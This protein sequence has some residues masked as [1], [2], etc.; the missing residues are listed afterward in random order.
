MQTLAPTHTAPGRYLLLESAFES[1][2]IALDSP[3]VHIGRAFTSD[4]RLEDHTVSRRHATIVERDGRTWILD[5]HATNGVFV[6]ELLVE[7]A[8]LED[9]DA[10]TLGR[11]VFTYLDIRTP[12]DAP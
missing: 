11:V 10:I 1:G 2:L 6:N 3:I 8:P 9:Q 4:V 12:V 7:A 5:E